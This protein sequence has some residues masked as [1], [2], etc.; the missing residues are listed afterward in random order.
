MILNDT[1]SK[2]SPTHPQNPH[3]SRLISK[4]DYSIP[5]NANSTRNRPSL[6]TSNLFIKDLY[7]QSF[8]NNVSSTRRP[9]GNSP[10]EIE[11]ILPPSVISTRNQLHGTIDVSE[12]EI[13]R[14]SNNSSRTS[15]ISKN[16][17]KL[18]SIKPSPKNNLDRVPIRIPHSTKNT[19][20]RS[21]HEEEEFEESS[22]VYKRIEPSVMK[23][24]SPKLRQKRSSLN[25]TFD[26]PNLTF[27]ERI[28][29]PNET[30]NVRPPTGYRNRKP[31]RVFPWNGKAGIK[32]EILYVNEEVKSREDE[33]NY[34]QEYEEIESEKHEEELYESLVIGKDEDYGE[35][36][37]EN[38]M[39]RNSETN[40]KRIKASTTPSKAKLTKESSYLTLTS[41]VNT[42]PSLLDHRIA[43]WDEEEDSEKIIKE[44]VSK[45]VENAYRNIRIIKDN[46]HRKSKTYLF[47]IEKNTNME[48]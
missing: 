25:K 45:H 42:N 18:P 8:L 21:Y 20:E 24:R 37:E 6:D 28:Q 3:K 17:V 44:I 22:L 1:L 11:N 43:N 41:A 27:D 15:N 30:F 33:E 23:E 2:R 46:F 39:N 4:F 47:H 26:V 48:W 5:R 35:D 31:V 19:I 40:R 14:G 38:I 36:T 13:I 34:T 7:P 12:N 9:R 10:F 29:P 32:E 16:S